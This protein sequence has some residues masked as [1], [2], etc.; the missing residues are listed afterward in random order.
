VFNFLFAYWLIQS[1][2]ALS[3]LG[4]TVFLY[5]EFRRQK[6]LRLSLRDGGPG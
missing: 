3:T 2:G 5:L 4:I 1:P 6:N